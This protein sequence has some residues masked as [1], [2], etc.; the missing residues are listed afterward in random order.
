MIRSFA[1]RPRR[2]IGSIVLSALATSMVLG[3]AAGAGAESA[4]SNVD[5]STAGGDFPGHVR[6]R[7]LGASNGIRLLCAHRHRFGAV[8]WHTIHGQGLHTH[9]E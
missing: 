9:D 5:A 3:D 8:Y 2:R 4:P 7:G 1:V 6:R